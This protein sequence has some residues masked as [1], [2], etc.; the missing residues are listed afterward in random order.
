M[1]EP[2]A[3]QQACAVA[4]G[5]KLAACLIKPWMA[6]VHRTWLASTEWLNQ[7]EPQS[8]VGA[9]MGFSRH[10]LRRVPGF[11]PEL[12]P[13]AMGFGDEYLFGCQLQE[14]GYRI[15]GRLNVC[16]EHHFA[17]S[18]LKRESWL[19][20]AARRGMVH[21]YVNYHW[22][23]NGYKLAKPRLFY[24]SC[25][26]AAWRARYGRSLSDEGCS[27]PELGLVFRQAELRDHLRQR[28]RPRNYQRHG[29]VKRPAP[30][31]S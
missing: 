11:D 12:G 17:R 22:L 5:V 13:G 19:D 15:I 18:R 3:Q 26:L 28:S 1:C 23:H 21:G 9:N 4:G 20:A 2:F 27:V 29:L 30:E 10:V 6:H 8:M 16:V 24:R 7:Q 14:A 31:Q 25:Q